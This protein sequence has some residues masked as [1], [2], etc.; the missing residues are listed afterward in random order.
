MN[1]KETLN[2]YADRLADFGLISDKETFIGDF[3]RREEER[4][5]YAEMT[6]HFACERQV[7]RMCK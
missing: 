6:A 1:K 5:E 2:Q 3:E 4:A 7:A